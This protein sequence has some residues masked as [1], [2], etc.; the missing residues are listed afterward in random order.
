MSIPATLIYHRPGG[1]LR[2]LDTDLRHLL[3]RGERLTGYLSTLH[4]QIEGY[5]LQ[6]D[7]RVRVTVSVP[8]RDEGSLPEALWTAAGWRTC[9][10]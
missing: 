3:P 7:G 10:C 9:G 5:D 4:L 1:H 6:R 8:G 2:T